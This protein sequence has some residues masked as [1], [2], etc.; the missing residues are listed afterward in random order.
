[1]NER[2]ELRNLKLQLDITKMPEPVRDVLRYV[3][4]VLDEYEE[5]MNYLDEKLPDHKPC[6][7]NCSMFTQK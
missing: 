3:V 1:M 5:R 4:Q 7:E 2:T 6:T